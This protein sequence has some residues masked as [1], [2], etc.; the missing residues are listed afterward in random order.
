M[1]CSEEQKKT[2]VER[3]IL[4]LKL[5]NCQDTLI[6][7]HL[8]KGISGGQKKRTSIAFELLSNPQVIVLDEPTSGLDSLTSYVIIQYLQKLSKEENKTVIMTIHQPNS[9]IFELFDRVLLMA[10]GKLVFQGSTSQSRLYFQYNF[11]FKCPQFFNPA[12][13]FMKI[14]HPED[15][16][17]RL[18]YEHYFMTYKL[19]LTPKIDR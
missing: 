5:E 16:N 17:N 3:L 10:E 19:V 8:I 9:D 11:G 12:D 15:L 18:R 2:K 13:Y 1:I 14:I 7:S 4:Q 6:G